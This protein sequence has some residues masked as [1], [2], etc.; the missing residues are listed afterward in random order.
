MRD[1]N[2]GAMN[3]ADQPNEAVDGGDGMS[4]GARIEELRRRKGQSLQQVADAVGV[5]K[6]HIWE[7]EKGRSSNPSFELV[8]RLAKHFGVSVE[9]LAGDAVE[10]ELHH[11]FCRFLSSVCI[12]SSRIARSLS[13]RTLA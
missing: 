1:V 11:A 4:V 6:A 8:R 10:N 2:D 5:S 12:M 9:V 7:L 13:S 3:T